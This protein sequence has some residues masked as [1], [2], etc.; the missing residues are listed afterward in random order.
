MLA[1][2]L[3]SILVFGLV[4]ALGDLHSSPMWLDW[5]RDMESTVLGTVALYD[6]NAHD[7]IRA[8]C[9]LKY[10]GSDN[11][12]HLC[13][14]NNL[15]SFKNQ[16]GRNNGIYQSFS[17]ISACSKAVF[18]IES[19]NLTVLLDHFDSAPDVASQVADHFNI[20]PSQ[21]ASVQ[22]HIADIIKSIPENAKAVVC[23]A[24]KARRNWRERNRDLRVSYS[25]A[26][27]VSPSSVLC[28]YPF[29]DGEWR[30]PE[31]AAIIPMGTCMFR[32][33][34]IHNS[35]WYFVSDTHTA[36]DI[37]PFRLNTREIEFRPVTYELKPTVVSIA[38][39]KSLIRAPSQRA[40]V[41]RLVKVASIAAE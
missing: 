15:R 27:D 40:R 38:E 21:M 41:V 30:M 35:I 28:T 24:A 5:V 29:R 39:M 13:T 36:A 17:R 37:P 8:M 16:R 19:R 10:D 33:L 3:F 31:M 23:P 1:S 26:A 34:Y 2:Q 7:A 22:D 11:F 32:D 4:G 6:S 9:L 20:S 25:V 18:G 14:S 12:I